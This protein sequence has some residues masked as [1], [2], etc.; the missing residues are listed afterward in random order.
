MLINL[1]CFLQTHSQRFLSA[2]SLGVLVVTLLECLHGAHK[3]HFG[4]SRC[5]PFQ[6]GHPPNSLQITKRQSISGNYV[7][8]RNWIA[9]MHISTI[10]HVDNILLV[11]TW[12]PL[13]HLVVSENTESWKEPM[14]F[15][16]LPIYLLVR[17]ELELRSSDGREE[18]L[19]HCV[20][21]PDRP[22]CSGN[23]GMWMARPEFTSLS[24]ILNTGHI[25]ESAGFFF[26]VICQ[27]PGPS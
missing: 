12:H 27:C 26:F 3:Q 1:T 16:R 21:L 5:L 25:L 17:L 11:S 8:C 20:I 19:C 14:I 10:L 9:L 4:I 13:L 15:S 22:S 24:V 6:W 2:F 23:S 18:D 7:G